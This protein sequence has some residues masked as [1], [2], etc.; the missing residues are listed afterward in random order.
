MFMMDIADG[1]EGYSFISIFVFGGVLLLYSIIASSG[2]NAPG[3]PIHSEV[4]NE[5][6]LEAIGTASSGNEFYVLAGQE[7]GGERE[8]SFIAPNG[9]TQFLTAAPA[10]YSD[11]TAVAEGTEATV[12]ITTYVFDNPVWVPWTTGEHTTYAFFVPAGGILEDYAV[13]K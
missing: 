13:G 8:L 6:S 12:I 4:S 10:E 1:F 11:I 7:P 5:Y 2:A 9:G 3:A